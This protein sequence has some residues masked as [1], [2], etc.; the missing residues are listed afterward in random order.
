M[1]VARIDADGNSHPVT[2]WRLEGGSAPIIDHNG[3]E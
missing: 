1:I 2:F 3:Y